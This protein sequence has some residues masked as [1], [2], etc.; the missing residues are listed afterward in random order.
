MSL[1][2][3]GKMENKRTIIGK[4]DPKTGN[5]IYKRHDGRAIGPWRKQNFMIIFNERGRIVKR[6]RRRSFMKGSDYIYTALVD[7]A[8]LS[9]FVS[10]RESPIVARSA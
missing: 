8:G 1:F 3:S 7:I 5:P 9:L 4:L 2:H 10:V 6:N